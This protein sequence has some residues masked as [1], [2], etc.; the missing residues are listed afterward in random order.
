MCFLPG[1]LALGATKG[2]TKSKAM[3][4]NFLSFEDL[5]NLRLAEDLAKTCV[6]TYFVTKTGLAPEISYFHVEVSA[7]VVLYTIFFLAFFCAAALICLLPIFV[8]LVTSMVLICRRF[9]NHFSN[10]SRITLK[11]GMMAAIR[12]Q[13]I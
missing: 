6:E 9:D 8:F 1:T 10:S 7:F 11:K 2:M 4:E 13:N 5:E 3:K 12:A